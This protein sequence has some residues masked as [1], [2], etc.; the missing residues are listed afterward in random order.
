MIASL[1]SIVCGYESI[2]TTLYQAGVLI[3]MV[4][5]ALQAIIGTSGH[6]VIFHS[7][8]IPESLPVALC[9]HFHK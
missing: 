1:I 9:S 4:E 3:R 6:P 5:Y 7:L 8:A 2:C